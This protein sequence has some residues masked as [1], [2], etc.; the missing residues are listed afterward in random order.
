MI[1]AQKKYFELKIMFVS[2][3]NRANRK[4]ETYIYLYDHYKGIFTLFSGIIVRLL[5]SHAIKFDEKLVPHVYIEPFPP[6]VE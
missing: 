5:Y 4:R 3:G 2:Q 1:A 6:E